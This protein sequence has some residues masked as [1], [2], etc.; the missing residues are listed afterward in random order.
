[1]SL[2]NAQINLMGVFFECPLKTSMENCPCKR[3]HSMSV[4]EKMQELLM[5]EE[6]EIEALLQYH[7]TCV[8]LRE[9]GDFEAIKKLK[10]PVDRAP[11]KPDI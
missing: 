4:T 6:E 5:L 1:M 8:Y 7:H 3:I 10:L 9:K 11:F 2:S